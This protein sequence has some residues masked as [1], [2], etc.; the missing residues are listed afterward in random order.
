MQ[1]RMRMDAAPEAVAV[2]VGR[3]LL[4]QHL[5]DDD[6]VQR[7]LG[8]DEHPAHTAAR[9]LPVQRIAAPE[10]F[11]E[12]VAEEIAHG[13]SKGLASTKLFDRWMAREVRLR[14]CHAC[15]STSTRCAV[16]AYKTSSVRV[17][18]CPGRSTFN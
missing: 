9:Q 17:D 7:V 14:L 6:A 5:H 8:R 3:E 16:A 2:D 11:N 1:L 13:R 10:G 15:S 12:L 4:S 18:F